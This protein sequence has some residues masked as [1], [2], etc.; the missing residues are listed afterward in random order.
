VSAPF[1]STS[2]GHSLD[3]FFEAVGQFFSDLAAVHWGALA[4]GL[5]FFGLNLTLRSR[6]FF[7]SLRAAYPGAHSA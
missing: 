7:H 1:A 2:I 4:V 3:A 6:A 5:A